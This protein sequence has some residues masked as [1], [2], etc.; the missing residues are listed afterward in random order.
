M[1]EAGEPV[2][3]RDVPPPRHRRRGE[4]ERETVVPRREL[5]GGARRHGAP[6]E[7]RPLEDRG[8]H[9]G[10]RVGGVRIDR[11]D[12]V[13]GRE[14]QLAVAGPQPR[15]ADADAVGAAHAVALVVEAHL[16]ARRGAGGDSIQRGLVDAGD[17]DVRRG[18][19]PS[20]IVGDHREVAVRR[21]AVLGAEARELA[22]AKPIQTG[23]VRPEPNRP[24]AVL[25]DGQD[26][27]S[28]RPLVGSEAVRRPLGDAAGPGNRP[29]P[30]RTVARRADR[31]DDVARQPLLLAVL[32]LAGVGHPDRPGVRRQPHAALGVVDHRERDARPAASRAGL[33]RG[34]T[35][36]RRRQSTR[37]P[38]CPRGWPRWPSSRARA[39]RARCALCRCGPHRVGC[40]PNPPF[41]VLG[42]RG[43]H[44]V[45]QALR[46]R[47]GRD[48]R[49]AQPHQPRVCPDPQVAL[50]I[51][52]EATWS[53]LRGGH[54]P[55]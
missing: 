5:H 32:L 13:G 9:R 31:R 54:S 22:V 17:A 25:V 37:G 20:A 4:V 24:V 12:P 8:K 51:E 18:P 7:A 53:R 14:P 48:A 36:R 26:L 45:G 47:E 19:Q 21:K 15:V 34:G 30:Q 50:A 49:L 23:L 42:E 28:G 46:P 29:Q 43:R 6:G 16:G 39:R 40:P 27:A 35:R 1:V 2:A 44:P 41:G 11:H 10:R 55:A 52:E 33:R 38:S 3:E